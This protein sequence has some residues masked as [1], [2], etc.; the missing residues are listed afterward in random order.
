MKVFEVTIEHEESGEIK[1]T[2]Q[3]VTQSYC[4]MGQSKNKR[5]DSLAEVTDFFS[6]HCDEHGQELIG[7]RYVLTISQN[8]D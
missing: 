8:I 1:R 4:A 5:K 7:V 3:Y 6:N 2:V